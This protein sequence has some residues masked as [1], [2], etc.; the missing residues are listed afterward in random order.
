M[1]YLE[2]RGAVKTGLLIRL[3]LWL[4]LAGAAVT[5]WVGV[6][7]S[8]LGTLGYGAFSWG[9]IAAVASYGLAAWLTRLSLP[10]G[11]RLRRIVTMLRPL[12]AGITWPQ[13]VLVSLLAGLGEEVVFRVLLQG[14]LAEWASP[15]WSIVI[16]S[17]L[18][19]LLH[20][21]TPLYF[22]VTLVFGLFLGTAYWLSGSVILVV[23]WHA[24]YDLL[25]I[26]VITRRPEWLGL[27]ADRTAKES[28]LR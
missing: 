27:C 28:G 3:Q 15:A 21:M 11:R 20:A 2:P 6:P 14:W 19:A 23:T 12:L 13:L 26:A 17:V 8:W 1:E 24:V 4:L 22:F 25:A 10:I 5:L 18:F 9:C 7:F 16:A